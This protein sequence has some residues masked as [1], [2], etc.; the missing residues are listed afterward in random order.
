M[1]KMPL[2]D[3]EMKRIDEEAEGAL[4]RDRQ[5]KPIRKVRKE[6]I[7][8]PK[9]TLQDLLYNEI[10][11]KR[12]PRSTDIVQKPD[13][14]INYFIKKYALNDCY[15]LAPLIH[16]AKNEPTFIMQKLIETT[17][18]KNKV[19][20]HLFDPEIGF[21]EFRG[22]RKGIKPPY[23]KVVAEVTKDEAIRWKSAH[24]AFW[25]I[26]IEIAFAK[27]LSKSLSRNSL[28]DDFI[29]RNNVLDGGTEGL[30]YA[31]LTGRATRIYALD[32]VP[33]IEPFEAE[34]YSPQVLKLYNKINKCLQSKKMICASFSGQ[35]KYGMMDIGFLTASYK[36]YKENIANGFKQLLD[37][38]RTKPSTIPDYQVEW[39]NIFFTV[40]CNEKPKDL[41]REVE[42][43]KF[44]ISSPKQQKALFEAYLKGSISV[45]KIPK[46]HNT[47]IYSRHSYCIVGCKE[48]DGYKYVII[49]N[50][51]GSMTK[52]DYNKKIEKL[53]KE[54]KLPREVKTPQ[55]ID[56]AHGECAMELNHFYKKFATI[57]Y[58]YDPEEE[59]YKAIRK[60]FG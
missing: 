38:Y 34:T 36:R 2:T 59:A 47:G 31:I 39:L 40:I 55:E 33:S 7:R 13:N 30:A 42:N 53:R 56:N 25:P 18:D 4:I 50:P 27:A 26:V 6:Y 5:A 21:H 28:S 54:G 58:E 11:G 20:V 17:A 60:M 48:C 51:Y 44:D 57:D 43:F 10:E 19:K 15:L 29:N 45:K 32:N 41:M 22:K 52:I 23:K 3:E 24:K 12:I 46:T 9:T 37:N 49:A 35:P 14:H 8:D 1:I 16:L